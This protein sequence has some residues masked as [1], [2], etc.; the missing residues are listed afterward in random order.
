MKT[1]NLTF[2]T[3]GIRAVMGN[4]ST[5]L[6]FATIEAITHALICTLQKQNL[7]GSVVITYDSRNHSVEFS[8]HRKHFC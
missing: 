3:A 4:S 5:E 8:Q 2:G 7:V 1:C 6:N